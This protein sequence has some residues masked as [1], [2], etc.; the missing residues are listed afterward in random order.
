ME[1][2]EWENVGVIGKGG[3]STVY[4]SVLKP[5]GEHIAVKQIDIEGMTKEQIVGIKGEIETM[6][7]LS[8]NNIVSYI[9]TQQTSNKIFILL[10]FAHRG[11]IRQQYQRSGPLNELQVSYCLRQILLGLHYL[12]SNGI[13]HRDI[14]CANCLISDSG[15]I[16]LADFGASKRFES[17][18]IVS[19]LKGTPHWMAPEVSSFFRTQ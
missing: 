14:K 12:H 8:H 2:Y 3:S 6:K 19:G 4:K 11:S 13:A 18:S 1:T 16:K 10:E 9:G 5:L 17:D 7:T 15:M